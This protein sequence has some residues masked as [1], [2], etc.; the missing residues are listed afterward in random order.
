MPLSVELVI[1]VT[2]ES[3]D[4][5]PLHPGRHPFT[6]SHDS[7]GPALSY[8]L[9]VRSKR[10][11]LPFSN[12]STAGSPGGVSPPGSHRTE[13]DSLPSF[14]SSHPSFRNLPSTP[15]ERRELALFAGAHATIA[16]LS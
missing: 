14:R 15:S 10:S 7:D 13:R 12:K 8:A 6:M 16:G 3:R 4:A 2:W 11:K 9:K 5:S 1:A